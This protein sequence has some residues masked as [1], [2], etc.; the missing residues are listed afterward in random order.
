MILPGFKYK[1][2]DHNKATAYKINFQTTTI[3]GH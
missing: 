1:M 3:N 2:K